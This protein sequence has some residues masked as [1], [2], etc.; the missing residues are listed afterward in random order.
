MIDASYPPLCTINAVPSAL[1]RT[2]HSEEHARRF[3]AGEIRFGLLQH[4][5]VIEGSRQDETEG[6]ASIRWNLE[7]E[8]P[9]LHN[10]TYSGSSLNLYYVLCTSHPAVCR[11][12]LAKF[13]SF[14]VRINEP[15]T[16]LKRICAAWKEDVRASSDA[17]ITPVLYNKGDVVEP[18]PY[19]IASPSLTYAQKPPAFSQEQEYRYVLSC[20]VGTKEEPFL[21]LNVEPCRDIC[22]LVPTGT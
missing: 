6:K 2:F 1:L 20:E 17:F 22:T 16:L 18:P 3:I 11:C 14:T 13:G 21:T 12:H 15:L 19:F 10:V 9:N 8:N 4:Y 7:D 5:R